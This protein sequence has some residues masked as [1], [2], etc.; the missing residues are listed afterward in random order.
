MYC[1]RFMGLLL[2][3]STILLFSMGCRPDESPSHS[4]D[5]NG[6]NKKKTVEV[7]VGGKV[8]NI[9]PDLSYRATGVW[10]NPS[11]RPL[12]NVEKERMVTI[13]AQ[14]QALETQLS[15]LDTELGALERIEEPEIKFRFRFGA[16][17]NPLPPP[18]FSSDGIIDLGEFPMEIENHTK[19]PSEQ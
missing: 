16:S 18:D 15:E 3:I 11:P 17:P 7:T 12:T 4:Q 9:N 10:T 6:E 19:T 5:P 14:I 1:I 8:W 2:I 13:K